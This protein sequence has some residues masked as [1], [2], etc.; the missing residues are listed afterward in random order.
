VARELS[1]VQFSSPGGATI[2]SSFNVLKHILDRY[3][4][5]L[6]AM[7]NAEAM[8]TGIRAISTFAHKTVGARHLSFWLVKQNDQPCYVLVVWTMTA[9]GA[10]HLHRVLLVDDYVPIRIILRNI[11]TAY[12]DLRIVGEACDGKQA[13]EQVAACQPDI[14]LMDYNM[15]MMNG[16]EAARLIK[17]S[18]EETVIIGLCTVQDTYITEGFLEAGALAVIFKDRIDHLHSTIREAFLKRASSDYLVTQ[19]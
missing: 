2:V 1:G 19:H 8:F 10:T 17:T 11:L 16:I 12:V 18:W 13:I 7:S 9:I 4:F 14:I 3:I 15:P 5:R 6:A